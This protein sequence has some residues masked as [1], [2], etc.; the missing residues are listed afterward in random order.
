MS[1]SQQSPSGIVFDRGGPAHPMPIVLVHAG[2]ADRRMWQPQWQDLTAARHTVRLDLRGFGD[3]TTPPQGPVSHVSD[4]IETLDHL[5]IARCHL[6]GSSLGGG[7][8]TEVALTRPD[9]V[10][11]LLLCP[12]GGSL[13]A[14][15]TPDL[16]QF[17]ETEKSALARDDLDAAVDTNISSWVVGHDRSESEVDPAVTAAVRPMQRRAFD[18]TAG[19]EDV[20]EVEMEPPALDRLP[21]LA[22]PTMVLVGG[23]DMA[24]THDA[25]QRVCA[26]APTVRRVDWPEVAHLPSMEKTTPFLALLLEWIASHE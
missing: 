9:L 13:L 1:Q 15:L 2:I 12:P 17:F 11:S 20:A 8:V 5:N 26:G 10:Q 6:V 23:H 22:A 7:V 4:V 19:W 14:E 25:A 16:Q 24:T 18:I 3:S 21:D